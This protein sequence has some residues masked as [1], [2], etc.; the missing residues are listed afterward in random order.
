MVKFVDQTERKP[1]LEPNYSKWE[2]ENSKWKSLNI[3][4]ENNILEFPENYKII[5]SDNGV[6]GHNTF[7]SIFDE[8]EKLCVFI[9]HREKHIG[10]YYQWIEDYTIIRFCD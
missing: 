5:Q 6:N 4:W 10:K 1:P 9:N 3:K 7:W 2:P 8:N